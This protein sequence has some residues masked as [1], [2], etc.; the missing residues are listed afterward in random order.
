MFRLLPV[1]GSMP[2]LGELYTLIR[3]GIIPPHPLARDL[4]PRAPMLFYN[5]NAPKVAG[6]TVAFG[7]MLY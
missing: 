1:E 7:A 4:I 6:E 2:Q 3:G 5:I